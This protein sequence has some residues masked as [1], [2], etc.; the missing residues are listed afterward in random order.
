MCP[1]SSRDQPRL[2]REDAGSP[3]P[4]VRRPGL[5][6]GSFK[7]TALLAVKVERRDEQLERFLVRRT[8]HTAFERADPIDA[9][10]GAFG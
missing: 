3:P 9:D 5:P 2:L 4:G 8:P 10:P 1:H 6:G 7:C